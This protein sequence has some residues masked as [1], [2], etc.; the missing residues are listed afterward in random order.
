MS[1][2]NKGRFF[3]V[4]PNSIDRYIFNERSSMVQHAVV[5]QNCGRYKITG[6]SGKKN[7]DHLLVIAAKLQEYDDSNSNLL[8]HT[9]VVGANCPCD[10]SFNKIFSVHVYKR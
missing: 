7:L 6:V 2:I 5:L 8:I 10:D 9:C 1:T 3:N 4:S